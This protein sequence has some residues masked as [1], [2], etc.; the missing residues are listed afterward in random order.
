MAILFSARRFDQS[1]WDGHAT[2]A[3]S[4]AERRARVSSSIANR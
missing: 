4:A 3:G 1:E 2:A